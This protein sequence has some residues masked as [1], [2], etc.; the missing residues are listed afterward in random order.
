[1]NSPTDEA[2]REFPRT[3]LTLHQRIHS[4]SSTDSAEALNE[5]FSRYWLPLYSFLRAAGET[6]E[7]A[8]DFL[9]GFISAEILDRDQLRNWNPEKGTMRGFLKTCL[10]RFRKK[11]RRREMALKRG[12]KKAETHVSIDLDWAEG[13]FEDH[14][15]DG[16]TPDRQFDREW[17]SAIVNQATGLLAERYAEKGK[18]EE[19]RL[20]LQ[21]LEDR[22]GESSSANYEVIA[23]RLGTTQD[24]VKQRMRTFRARFHQCLRQIVGEFVREADIGEEIAFLLATLRG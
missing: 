10:D 17:A 24:A 3:S 15:T 21:N 4:R 19:F 5:F 6:H 9:Q 13:Y 16:D 1:M 14:T 12:G 23:T 8:S 11:E 22:G 20:L 7:D 18:G 2:G